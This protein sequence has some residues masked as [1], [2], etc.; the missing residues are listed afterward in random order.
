MSD[1]DLTMEKQG[2]QPG[3]L[4]DEQPSARHIYP[5]KI[6]ALYARSVEGLRLRDSHVTF[7]GEGMPW[8]GTLNEIENCSRVHVE[9]EAD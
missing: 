7:V 9:W 1:I 3:G 4:F 5:H 2:T 6:P 8:D